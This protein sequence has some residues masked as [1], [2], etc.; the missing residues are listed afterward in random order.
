MPIVPVVWNIMYLEFGFQTLKSTVLKYYGTFFCSFLLLSQK[1]YHG[2]K[3]CF[4]GIVYNGWFGEIIT[5]NLVF[6]SIQNHDCNEV[7]VPL[8]NFQVHEWHVRILPFL[9]AKSN[10]VLL[11]IH[12]RLPQQGWHWR[13]QTWPVVLLPL[14]S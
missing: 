1:R 8:G 13:L 10:T 4:T 11:H 12:L 5:E 7:W 9:L 6:I 14:S 2:K 3:K